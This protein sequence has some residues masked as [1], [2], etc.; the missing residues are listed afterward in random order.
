MLPAAIAPRY[1]V[2]PQ[3]KVSWALRRVGAILRQ[4]M[5][6]RANPDRGYARASA[7]AILIRMRTMPN[8]CVVTSISCGRDHTLA[9]LD[10]GRVFGWGMDGSGR[11]APSTPEYCSTSKAPTKA[12]EVNAPHEMLSISAGYGVT[13]SEIACVDARQKK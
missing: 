8:L 11:V 5:P 13:C 4:A 1:R 2:A 9:L 7:D 3:A 12:V 10:S 6:R